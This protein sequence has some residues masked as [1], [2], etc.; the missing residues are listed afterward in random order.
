VVPVRTDVLKEHIASPPWWQYVPPKC[1]FL[2]EPDSII[3]SQKTAFFTVTAVKTPNLNEN[4]VCKN[5]IKKEMSHTFPKE[6]L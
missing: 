2:Q 3:M 4:V 1:R 5:G 6:T